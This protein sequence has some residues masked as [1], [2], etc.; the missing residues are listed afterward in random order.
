MRLK[1]E[2]LAWI[3]HHEGEKQQNLWCER[4]KLNYIIWPTKNPWL[5][6]LSAKPQKCAE[7]EYCRNGSKARL[8]TQLKYKA[9]NWDKKRCVITKVEHSNRDARVFLHKSSPIWAVKVICTFARSEALKER[10]NGRS[11]RVNQACRCSSQER[12]K[13]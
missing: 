7:G 5:N 1:E 3:L 13:L 9:Q 8:F 11:Q 4:H 2:C 12:L 10:A 6:V